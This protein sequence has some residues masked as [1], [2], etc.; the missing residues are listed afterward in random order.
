LDPRLTLAQYQLLYSSPGGPP[1]RFL[2]EALATTTKG[3]LTGVTLTTYFGP[4]DPQGLALVHDL[5]SDAGPLAAPAGMA[6]LVGGGAADVEDVVSGIGADFPRTA[7]FILISSYAVLFLLLRSVV[8]PIKAVLMNSLS[9]LA[10]FGALVW[11]FQDGNLSMLLGIRP[12]GFVETTQPVIL[13]CVLFGLSMDYEV[14]LLTRMRESWDATHDNRAAVAHGLERSGRIVTSAAL[15]VVVVSGSFAFADIVLIKALGLGIAIAVALDATVVRALLVPA[16][17]RLIGDWNWWLPA[18]LARRLRIIATAALCLVVLAGCGGG[19]ILANAP[20]I[21]RTPPTPAPSATRAPDPQPI[22]FPRD[23]EPHDRLTEWWYFTGHLVADDGRRFGFEFVIFRAERGS[24]PVTWASHL[25][26]TDESGGRFLYGQRAAIG[27]AVFDTPISLALSPPAPAFSLAIPTSAAASGVASPVDPAAYLWPQAWVYSQSNGQA[28]IEAKLAPAEASQAGGAFGLELQLDPLKAPVLHDGNGWIDFGP[29][30]G[31][32]YYS[33]TRLHVSGSLT[34]DGSSLNVRGEA[35]F[36]H[37]WGDF[38]SVGGGGWDWFA[39]NLA[40]GTDLTLSLVRGADGS[41]PLVYGTYVAANGRAAHLD[42]SQFSV[43]SVGAWTSPHTG[44]VYPAGWQIDVPSL[45]LTIQLTPTLPDQELD[46]RPTT[47]VAY[48]EGSQ[49]VSA[50]RAGQP[51]RGE[52]YVELTGYAA[53]VH[54]S[55]AP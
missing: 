48:W 25:A 55:A 1:D 26:L 51:L 11:I 47:G 30:G 14:F 52:A 9:I 5:R 20:I 46:T 2:Q 49:R 28:D 42:R 44:A 23:E 50:T 35:W 19:P 22:V 31:S 8:L 34:L 33:R 40:D 43:K 16:T 54:A 41:L 3:N 24:A 17:M 12:L 4:N 21:E 10:S 36:D 37:Q 6:V 13:F 7:A 53:P 45:D 15:I 27:G 39:V 18:A 38:I 32:Y 29:A